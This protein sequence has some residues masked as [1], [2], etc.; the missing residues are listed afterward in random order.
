[1]NQSPQDMDITRLLHEYASGD[2]QSLDAVVSAVYDELRRMARQQLR[3]S[4]IH[5][6]VETTVLV[7]EAYEKLVQGKTQALQDR[8]HFF[9]IASRAMRQIVVDTYRANSAA[10]RGGGEIAL[11]VTVNDVVDL[12]DPQRLLLLDEAL[13][14][15]AAQD[16]ELAEVVDLTCFAGLSTQEI[17]DLLETNVRTVQRKLKRAQA[18]LVRLSQ[19]E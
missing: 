9:A 15:L 7:H 13:T 3:R 5:G 2:A 17:A 18:W 6:Q 19:G 4:S 16:E 1:M 14:S 12:A 10:K 11:T 8:R